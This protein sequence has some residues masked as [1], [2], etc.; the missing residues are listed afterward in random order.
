MTEQEQHRESLHLQLRELIWKLRRVLDNGP[1]G[2]IPD[3]E[4]ILKNL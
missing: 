1:D 4:E 2:C 3:T